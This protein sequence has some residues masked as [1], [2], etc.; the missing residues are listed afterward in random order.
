[1]D[2]ILNDVVNTLDEKISLKPQQREI[3]HH[4]LAKK[5]VFVQLPTGY[6]KSLCFGIVPLVLDK[7]NTFNY[8]QLL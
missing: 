6:G 8:T 4:I 1:M 7:V 3:V 5:N 2:E